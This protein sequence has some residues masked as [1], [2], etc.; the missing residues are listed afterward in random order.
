MS[1]VVAIKSSGRKNANS[2]AL[3]EATAAVAAEGHELRTHELASLR[4]IGCTGCGSCRSGADG[5][6]IRDGLTPVLA[7]VAEADLLVMGVPVY[8][9]YLS[10]IFKSFIDRWYGFRDAERNL[11]IRTGRPAHIIYSQGHPDPAAYVTMAAQ[12]DRV[13]TG[14]GFEPSRL[15]AAGLE[16]AGQAAKSPKLLEDARSNGAELRLLLT[17]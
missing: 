2:S 8:Y 1:V 9:S 14:Y 6:V 3:V 7:D 11:R 5:C 17:P 15:I 4:F 13:L 10:G 16:S 12:I